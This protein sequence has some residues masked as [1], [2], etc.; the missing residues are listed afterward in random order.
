MIR[1]A[2]HTLHELVKVAADA[3]TL[4]VPFTFLDALSRRFCSI[5][6]F[7]NTLFA[8]VH[9]HDVNCVE[10]SPSWLR[11]Q[12]DKIAQVIPKTQGL[13][14]NLGLIGIPYSQSEGVL[15][16]CVIPH[17]MGHFAFQQTEA[18]KK[19]DG[20]YWKALRGAFDKKSLSL[21]PREGFHWKDQLAYWSEEVFDSLAVGLIGPAYTLALV[22]LLE[23]TDLLGG[24]K[25][26]RENAVLFYERHPAHAFR[27]QQ[28]LVR[29]GKLGWRRHLET[30]RAP[31]AKAIFQ[32]EQLTGQWQ[33][34]G[35]THKGMACIDAFESLVQKI[36]KLVE[37]LTVSVD[38]G[39][40]EFSRLHEIVE[41]YLHQGS[42]H[43]PL[44]R[45]VRSA[46]PAS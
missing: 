39:V 37:D 2:W 31:C 20:E 43:Q 22:D 29:L 45:M 41:R 3:D 28:Q 15:Y 7:R 6:V 9:T 40:E 44:S 38:P 35:D 23:L 24:R 13:P 11:R 42:Y 10:I 1:N 8:V 12:T 33:F 25:E 32:V 19:L 18:A 14:E 27:V 5:P 26:A 16:N 30:V 36:H 34:G 17:E 4:N 46:T 21:D